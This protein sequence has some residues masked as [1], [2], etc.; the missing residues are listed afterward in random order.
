MLTSFYPSKRT[1]HLAIFVF[2]LFLADTTFPETLA[3]AQQKPDELI[4][5]GI[6][7]YNSGQYE[8][9]ITI[10][11]QAAGLTKDKRLLS[12]AF[13]NISLCY[14]QLGNIEST[15]EFIRKT[16]E[17]EPKKKVA[18]AKYAPEYYALFTEIVSEG[19]TVVSREKRP[20]AGIKVGRIALIGA[21]VIGV[22]AAAYFLWVRDDTGN[23][24]LNSTPTG[25]QVFLDGAD[26]GWKTN[27]TL[28][29]ISPGDH[30]IKLTKDGYADYEQ[31]V[32]VKRAK[33]E[34][35]NIT[36]PPI[37][38]KV[39]KPAGG[40]TWIR[41]QIVE[42]KW[43][44]GTSSS[45]KFL[46]KMGRFTNPTNESSYLRRMSLF[47]VRAPLRGG[48]GKRGTE[49]GDS[50]SGSVMA[51]SKGMR[52]LR[53]EDKNPTSSIPGNDGSRPEASLGPQDIGAQG[54][55][56]INPQISPALGLNKQGQ[57]S[58]KTGVA[59][60]ASLLDI[61]KVKIDLYKG[62]DVLETIESATEND[63][64]QNW[65]V[66]STLP[67]GT[68]YKIRISCATDSQIFG[69]SGGFIISEA[70]IAITKPTAAT[71]W[72]KGGTGVIKWTSSV[73]GNVKID[74]LKENSPYLPIVDNTP[75]NGSFT[76]TVSSDIED[77]MDY[78]IRI[79]HTTDSNL[80]AESP[81]FIITKLTYEIDVVASGFT[82]PHGITLDQAGYAHVVEVEANDVVKF[83]PASGPLPTPKPTW[84]AT[85]SA[86]GQFNQ[87][88]G[89]VADTAGG[90]IFVADSG[91]HRIQKFDTS[92]NFVAKIGGPTP[93]SGNGEFDTPYD[94][95]TDNYGN[96]Y[97]TDRNNTRVQ[98][99]SSSLTWLQ[100]WRVKGDPLGIACDNDRN[101]VYV[102][103]YSGK[104]VLV[105]TLDGA[106]ER[107][108]SV[109]GLPWCIAVDKAGFVYITDARNNRFLKYTPDGI[110]LSKTGKYGDAYDQFKK[111]VDI[112]VD[113]SGRVLVTSLENNRVQRFK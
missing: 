107:R 100:S 7:L 60:K 103:D 77:R 55:Y 13:F 81:S 106:Y 37:P 83:V 85:G 76:W 5:Q 22:T 8:S 91:N 19:P 99:F 82:S 94:I 9:A 66:P 47:R 113:S 102:V 92:G 10:L 75:N 3:G 98:K 42:I 86:D 43:E 73:S 52:D 39:T 61:S 40:S 30:M 34:T 110:L 74:L 21:A 62:A 68:D 84:G 71:F 78:R 79:T 29:D 50:A 93:G 2:L 11:N 25:A 27:C 4:K 53:R 87:P 51:S 111:P 36:I 56:K 26:T 97:V 24:Q 80:I 23:I 70:K 18:E 58:S 101:S 67:D 12:E 72:G 49:F 96:I 46:Q 105:Y 38:I 14:F 88:K 16:I 59:E 1:A 45:L 17:V 20:G 57:L 44:T 64:N 54:L 15:K 32:S 108:W 63:G 6:E 31:K 90:F 112:Y 109:A 48:N 28:T 95:A 104:Q 35:L 69:E 33:T 89:I 41:G 65:T